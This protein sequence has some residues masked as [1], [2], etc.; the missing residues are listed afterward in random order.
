[1]TALPYVSDGRALIPLSASIVAERAHLRAVV[2]VA[3]GPNT[4]ETSTNFCGPRR[5]AEVV[6]GLDAR[7]A[8]RTELGVRVAH[9]VLRQP[10]LPEL[11]DEVLAR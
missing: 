8:A 2:E 4:Y 5:S 3:E 9:L 1:M 10:A 7:R 11:R 6:G